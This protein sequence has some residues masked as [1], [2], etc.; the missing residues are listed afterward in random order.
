MLPAGLESYN[1]KDRREIAPMPTE[2]PKALEEKFRRQRAAWTNYRKFPPG[3]RR[4]TAGWVA[5]A[6]KEET[7]IKRLDK[8][9]EHSARNERIE[10]M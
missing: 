9:I 7:R 10:F 8:L 3:Y 4:V 5:S 1:A 2:M 6:K